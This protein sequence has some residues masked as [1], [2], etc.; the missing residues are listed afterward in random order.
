MGEPAIISNFTV[1]F[2]LACAVFCVAVLFC[3]DRQLR[4]AREQFDAELR[5]TNETIA[6]WTAAMQESASFNADM[7]EARALIDYGAH[8]EALEVLARWKQP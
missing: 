4:A 6:K 7:K 3:I 2:P 5:E 8:D 1:I